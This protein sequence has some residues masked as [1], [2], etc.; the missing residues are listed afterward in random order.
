MVHM[1]TVLFH[2]DVT[3]RLLRP[4]ADLQI[5][6]IVTIKNA[7]KSSLLGRVNT[8]LL[9]R[10]LGFNPGRVKPQTSKLQFTA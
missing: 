2:I 1:H 7:G 3:L 8:E 5:N 4:F 9:D 6:T 10:S